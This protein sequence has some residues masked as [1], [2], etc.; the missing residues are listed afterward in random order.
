MGHYYQ[1]GFVIKYEW[2]DIKV[3][4][5]IGWRFQR[6]RLRQNIPLETLSNRTLISI[7]TL[8]RLEKGRAKLETMIIVLRDLDMLEEL[9][10][11]I[12]PAQISP[13]E[14]VRMRGCQR[15]RASRPRTKK[16]GPFDTWWKR[17]KNDL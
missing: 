16:A 14:I 6:E 11:F 17:N 2:T 10:N 5:E 7:N 15:K 8:K 13:I 4:E 3:M 9:N 12:A 1:G